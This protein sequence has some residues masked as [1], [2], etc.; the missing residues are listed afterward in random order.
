MLCS[1]GTSPASIWIARSASSSAKSWVCMRA[2]GTRPDSISRIAASYARLVDAERPH[3]RELL[4]HH[5]IADEVGHRL[6]ALHAGEHDAGVRRGEPERLR[7]RRRRVRTRPRPRRRRRGRRS[8]RARDVARPRCSTSIVWSAPSSRASASLAASR[9]RPVTMI[10]SAPAA[11]A[12]MTLASPRWP[13]PRISTVSP[14]P[15]RGISTAQ[16]NPAPSGLNM[17]RD[18]RRD[19]GAN[20]VH[21][22]ERVEVHVVGVRAPQPRRA[23]ER[24]VAVTEH[25]AA[26]AAHVVAPAAAR[27]AVSARDERLDRDAIADVHAP[28]L[29]RAVAD[30]L[31]HAE[32]LVS[33]DQRIL[34]RDGAGVL[35]GVASADAARL[36]AEQRRV[37]G[38]LGYG[39]LAQLELARS[40]LH[41]RAT[42]AWRH[43]RSL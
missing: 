17:H 15:V 26:T 18:A 19:V 40:G 3:H 34:H 32:R 12:A 5:Q 2:S 10:R 41:D 13:G 30:R 31:D 1:P 14:G 7:H 16:R 4:H 43:R 6:E 27:G 29:R 37:V 35:L 38:Q 22:R 9:E 25:A 42:G 21:D 24:N 8:A 11:R 23:I 33:R 36:D 28:A 20:A 39:Q